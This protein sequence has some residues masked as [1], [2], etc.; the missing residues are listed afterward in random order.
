MKKLLVVPF[1][2][3]ALSLGGCGDGDGDGDSS[4]SD[5]AYEGTIATF[6]IVDTLLES[7]DVLSTNSK[8]FNNQIMFKSFEDT[9]CVDI[10]VNSVEETTSFVFTNCTYTIDSDTD[11]YAIVT[12]TCGSSETSETINGNLSMNNITEALT[13]TLSFS[14]A[15]D[16]ANCVIDLS[17][18]G[19]EPSGTMCGASA[20]EMDEIEANSTDICSY[21]D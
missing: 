2:V 18:V 1:M 21:I 6:I 9:D 7:L 20:A 5:E 10:D 19:D 3:I 17:Y 16:L 4:I 11:L 14:G 8:V 13:G 15:F 12:T